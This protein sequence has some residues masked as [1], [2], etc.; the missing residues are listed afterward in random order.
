MCR[1]FICTVYTDI[2]PHPLVS[3]IQAK[4]RQVLSYHLTDM[5][6][7]NTFARST[8]F[9]TPLKENDTYLLTGKEEV[10]AGDEEIGK[11]L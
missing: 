10:E 9:Q 3:G 1:L 11:G 5:H 7:H 6:D 2:S 8:R 4:L